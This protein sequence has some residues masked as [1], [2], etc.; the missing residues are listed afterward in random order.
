MY[1]GILTFQNTLNYGAELQAYALSSVI[2]NLGYRVKLINYRCSAV[3]KRESVKYPSVKHA[4]RHPINSFRE[5]CDLSER[6]TREEAFSNFAKDKLNLDILLNSQIEISSRYDVVIV[7]SDQVWN[8]ACTGG[9]ATYFLGDVEHGEIRKISYAASFGGDSVPVERIAEIGDALRD[10]DAIGVREASG[11]DLVTKASGKEATQVL[12]PTLLL[13]REDWLGVCGPN[14]HEKGSYI[15]V[16]VVSERK[17]TLSF[18]RK[19]SKEMSLPL[20][21][22][23]CYGAPKLSERELYMNDASPEEFLALIRDAALVVTSSFHGLALSLALGSEVRY[24]LDT[25]RANA[26]SRLENLAK[27]A[28]I[29]NHK[30]TSD[31]CCEAIDFNTVWER[32]RDEREKSLL[33]LANALE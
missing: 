23:D 11:V 32:I 26:N 14:R 1:I 25:K 10:F 15:F 9:D 28:G 20:V 22:I 5:I 12:D 13:T 21:I 4:L 29:E 31:G 30:V 16:Y 19:A 6:K 8:L 33:F 17:Q 3:S 18:A 27:L 2:R 24:S 7:G